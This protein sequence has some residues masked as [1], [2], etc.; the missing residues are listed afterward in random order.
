MFARNQNQSS[1]VSLIEGLE[2]RQL[3]SAAPIMHV[4]SVMPHIGITVPTKPTPGPK[5][6][7]GVQAIFFGT[8]SGTNPQGQPVSDHLTLVLTK[9]N[10]GTWNGQVT[11]VNNQ[12]KGVTTKGKVTFSA[13]GQLTSFETS[14]GQ[15]INVTGQASSDWTT[16]TGSYTSKSQDG[17]STGTFSLTRS[18]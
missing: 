12:N 5:I 16:I 7:K 3:M 13:T 11:I 2:S 6:V 4:G 8:T 17:T 18:A 15:T 14:N 1:K 9:N 10:D